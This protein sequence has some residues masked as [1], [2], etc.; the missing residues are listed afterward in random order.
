MQS[1]TVTAFVLHFLKLLVQAPQLPSSGV[2]SWQLHVSP[3]VQLRWV[4][5]NNVSEGI[6]GPYGPRYTVTALPSGWALMSLRHQSQHHL[7]VHVWPVTSHSHQAQP[8]RGHPGVPYYLFIL[9]YRRRNTCCFSVDIIY[10]FYLPEI[11]VYSTET[12]GNTVTPTQVRRLVLQWIG[13]R[14]FQE[15][16]HQCLVLIS[17]DVICLLLDDHV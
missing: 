12:C 16:K 5:R 2:P 11:A 9:P 13:L 10:I 6:S 8:A 3:P 17:L 7:H 14:G 4:E 15:R 1:L